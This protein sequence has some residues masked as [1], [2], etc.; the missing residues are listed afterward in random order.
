MYRY[1]NISNTD[2]GIGPSLLPAPFWIFLCSQITNSMLPTLLII[3]GHAP[4][5]LIT[6]KGTW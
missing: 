6:L 2:T 5:S 3:L 4:C 1:V